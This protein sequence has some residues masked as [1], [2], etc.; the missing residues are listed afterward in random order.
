MARV[1][2]ITRVI[3]DREEAEA[4]ETALI[5]EVMKQS[6]MVVTEVAADEG[7]PAAE[8]EYADIE[9]DVVDEEEEDYNTLMPAK[10]SHL[11]FGKSTVSEADMPMM[12][13]LGYFG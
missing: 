10:P 6:G 5:S 1:C 11:D 4:I 2:S 3:S 8:A 13:K 9:E 12:I 7:A